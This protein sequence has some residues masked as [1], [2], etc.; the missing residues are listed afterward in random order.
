MDKKVKKMIITEKQLRNIIKE[1]IC[2]ILT[3][4]GAFRLDD[5]FDVDFIK[6]ML[7]CNGTKLE[8]VKW[9]QF[10]LGLSDEDLLSWKNAAEQV[11]DNCKFNPKYRAILELLDRKGLLKFRRRR[12]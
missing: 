8:I 7:A 2:G 9:K 4:M 6:M 11:L 12:R 1:S 3:E 5:Q 10:L